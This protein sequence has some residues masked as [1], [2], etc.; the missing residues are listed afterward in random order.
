MTAIERAAYP[1][2][3]DDQQSGRRKFALALVAFP[4][5]QLLA[6]VHGRVVGYATSLIVQTDDDAP[7]ADVELTGQGSFSSHDP[8]G[9]TLYGADIAVDPDYQGRGVAQALWRGRRQIL[10]CYNLRRMLAYGRM[11]G[12]WAHAGKMTAHEYVDDVVAGKCYDRALTAHLRAGYRVIDLR[13]D[14]IADPSSLGWATVLEL[15]NPEY[16]AD[17]RA[18]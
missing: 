5:G 2:Y 14:L 18:E 11:P 8:A 12:Y 17:F 10:V 3:S 6:E 15:E 7:K 13:L 9:D 16:R 1:D 4:D